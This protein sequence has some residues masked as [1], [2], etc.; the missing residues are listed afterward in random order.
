[1]SRKKNI[2]ILAAVLLSFLC[3]CAH[4]SY[5]FYS[6]GP[7]EA[8]FVKPEEVKVFLVRPTEPARTLGAITGTYFGHG[9]A[10]ID[11]AAPS[12]KA[13]VAECGGNAALIMNQT[14]W[15]LVLNVFDVQAEVLRVEDK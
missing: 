6:N 5:S 13:K 9:H 14:Y 15:P 4:T 1:M 3:G 12:I 8:A 10:T 11:D 2:R 7:I